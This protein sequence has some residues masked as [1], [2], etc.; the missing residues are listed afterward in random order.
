M[1]VNEFFL[2]RWRLLPAAVI[3]AL[4]L[5]ASHAFFD[6]PH[7]QSGK[8]TL[9]SQETSTRAI[10][11]DSVTQKR[12]PFTPTSEVAWGEDNHTRIMMFA[13][14]LSAKTDPASVTASAED[15]NHTIHSLTVE[16]VG[17]VV[18]QEWLTA[19]VLKL[20]DQISQLSDVGDVLVGI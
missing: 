10:A 13:M 2:R 1:K 12:E 6:N 15:G 14:G 20:D 7:A 5:I 16:Y 3:C 8:L 4:S 17:P 19:V 18:G 11:V 9:I